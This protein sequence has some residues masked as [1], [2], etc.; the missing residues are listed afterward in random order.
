MLKHP[1]YSVSGDKGS[2]YIRNVPPGDYELEAWHEKYG[3]QTFKVSVKAGGT[4]E[5]AVSFKGE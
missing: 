1:F 3:S 5:Q 2:F 4:A